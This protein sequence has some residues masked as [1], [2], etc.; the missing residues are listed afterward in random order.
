MGIP[1]S[2]R[3]KGQETTAQKRRGIL[4]EREPYRDGKGETLTPETTSPSLDIGSDRGGKPNRWQLGDL[5]FPGEMGGVS[6]PGLK[7][8]R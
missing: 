2:C 7:A 6:I 1:A 5:Y 3:L 4:G 8:K